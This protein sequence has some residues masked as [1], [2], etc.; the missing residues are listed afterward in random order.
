MKTLHV[1][2]LLCSIYLQLHAYY[3]YLPINTEVWSENLLCGGGC[4][5][6]CC[7]IFDENCKS[8]CRNLMR[9]YLLQLIQNNYMNILWRWWIKHTKNYTELFKFIQCQLRSIFFLTHPRMHSLPWSWPR[10]R[11][12]DLSF[13]WTGLQLAGCDMYIDDNGFLN[14]FAN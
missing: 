13:H 10:K 14:I 9:S 6:N 7:P 4:G 3:I 11:P 5:S 12:I 1:N 8:N 2:G